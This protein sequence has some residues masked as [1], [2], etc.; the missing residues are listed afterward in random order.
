MVFGITIVACSGVFYHQE[1]PLRQS[2]YEL[3]ER[4]PA[5]CVEVEPLP[6]NSIQVIESWPGY[7]FGGQTNVTSKVLQIWGDAELLHPTHALAEQ[8]VVVLA[9]AF[10]I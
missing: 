2:D 6:N 5:L 4:T 3:L 9:H 1:T 8:F 10:P 7:K